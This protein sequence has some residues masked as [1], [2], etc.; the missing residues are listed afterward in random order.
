MVLPVLEATVC[1]LRKDGK[2]ALIDYT[3]Y[4]HK[5]HK[6]YFSP[7]GGKVDSGEPIES[8]VRREVNEEQGI[9][10]RDLVYRGRVF[11]NNEKR[12]FGGKP[13]KW[14]FRVYYYDSHDFDDASAKSKEGKL[15]WVSDEEVP[16]LPMHEGDKIIWGLLKKYKEIDAEIIHEGERLTQS[17]LNSYKNF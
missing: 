14:S 15:D 2:T 17:I 8:A 3:S 5:L 4:D 10:V 9:K 1:F 11:F 12:F 6:G 16:K 13:A 7:P